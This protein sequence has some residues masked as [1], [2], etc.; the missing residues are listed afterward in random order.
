MVL[1]SIAPSETE[2]DEPKP[3]IPGEAW[4]NKKK[5]EK[6][7][8]TSH[9]KYLERQ[10]MITGNIYPDQWPRS[11]YTLKNVMQSLITTLQ[12]CAMCS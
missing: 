7:K 9:G 3:W 10:S 6:K 2:N 5:N 11:A 4:L 12:G 1:C 8:K